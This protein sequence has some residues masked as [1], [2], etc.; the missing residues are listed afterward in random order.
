MTAPLTPGAFVCEEPGVWR[1][2]NGR[3]LIRRF[4]P[5]RNEWELL[6]DGA[7]YDWLPTL[8]AAKA[9]PRTL[10]ALKAWPGTSGT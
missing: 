5:G 10:A 3:V 4:G 6:I 9:D 1:S 8:A 2:K 7:I